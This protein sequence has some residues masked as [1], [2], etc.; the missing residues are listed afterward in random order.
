MVDKNITKNFTYEDLSCPCCNRI[1]ICDRL[2][3]HMDLLQKMR[4][5]LNFPVIINSAYRCKRHNEDIGGTVNSQHLLFATDIRPSWKTGFKQR[6]KAIKV[7]V[8]EMDFDG[9]GDYPTFV[10]L[11]MR[12]EKARW[13]PLI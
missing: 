2:Y 3:Q 10:H 6:L 7:V 12:G 11:D 13:K 4:G 1:I 8:K 9:I 5:K